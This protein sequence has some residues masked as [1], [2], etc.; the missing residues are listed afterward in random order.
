MIRDHLIREIFHLLIR[1][2]FQC[3]LRLIDI[4][5]V[6]SKIVLKILSIGSENDYDPAALAKLKD[7]IA[8]KAAAMHASL[9]F[10]VSKRETSIVLGIP[11]KQ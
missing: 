10:E 6:R 1:R 3:E 2:F 9:N 7:S 11:L 5:L 4:D 8:T